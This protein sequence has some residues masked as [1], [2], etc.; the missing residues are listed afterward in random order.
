MI[1]ETNFMIFLSFKFGCMWS[2]IKINQLLSRNTSMLSILVRQALDLGLSACHAWINVVSACLPI[3]TRHNERKWK[4]IGEIS[5]LFDVK[6]ILCVKIPDPTSA[7][8]SHQRFLLYTMSSRDRALM[9]E[10]VREKMQNAAA[11]NIQRIWR[12]FLARRF[13]CVAIPGP[14]HPLI[15][16]WLVFGS[17]T[18]SVI[19]AIA[20]II[21]AG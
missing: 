5:V 20:T 10:E 13:V 18:Q 12:V 19:H 1:C 3:S 14:V 16:L 7:T 6:L 8:H 9:P 21:P 15:R 2:I 4:D 11:T 17:T